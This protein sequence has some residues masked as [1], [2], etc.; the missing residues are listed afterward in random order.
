[1]TTVMPSA[2]S[3]C[4]KVLVY[5]FNEQSESTE[6]IGGFRPVVKVSGGV[7]VHR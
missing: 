7:R 2:A 3:A 6:L 5:N 1:M 4:W